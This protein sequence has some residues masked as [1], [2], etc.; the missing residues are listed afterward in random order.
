MIAYEFHKHIEKCD[1]TMRTMMRMLRQSQCQW[2][3]N[4]LFDAVVEKVLLAVLK[5]CDNVLLADVVAADAAAVVV[6]I[7][8]VVVVGVEVVVI[9]VDVVDVV[10]MESAL[11]S[12]IEQ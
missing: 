10:D 8:V 2:Y 4:D 5:R 9:V 11:S 7:A 3:D 12:D 6:V 1:K